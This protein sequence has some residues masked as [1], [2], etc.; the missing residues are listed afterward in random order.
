MTELNRYRD[1]ILLEIDQKMYK[2]ESRLL[3]NFDSLNN[4]AFREI[5]MELIE[6]E[7]ILLYMLENNIYIELTNQLMVYM[8]NIKIILRK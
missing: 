7:N 1:K 4:E 5:Q 3:E 6:I 2:I 8:K